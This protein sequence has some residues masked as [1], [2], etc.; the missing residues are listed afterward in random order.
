MAISRSYLNYQAYLA[1]K[2]VVPIAPRIFGGDERRRD[3][4]RQTQSEN[5]E[6]PETRVSENVEIPVP[7]EKRRV[8]LLGCLPIPRPVEV[9]KWAHNVLRPFSMPGFST[10]GLRIAIGLWYNRPRVP[11]WSGLRSFLMSLS[12]FPEL[13]L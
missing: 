4:Q 9:R 1:F 8:L 7:A 13:Q 5:V 10:P 6:I 3:E 2:S 11:S 12:H